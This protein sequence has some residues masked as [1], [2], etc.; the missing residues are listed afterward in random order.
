MTEKK[1]G[2]WD[3]GK[4]LFKELLQ[5]KKFTA[6]VLGAV[7]NL[8]AFGAAKVGLSEEQ[9]LSASTHI[10]GLVGAYILGQGVADAGK[11]KAKIEAQKGQP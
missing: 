7:A 6:L 3:I 1:T 2:L 4:G 11:E 5:S 8:A 10:S 9:A